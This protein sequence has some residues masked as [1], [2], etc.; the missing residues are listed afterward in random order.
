M[1]SENDVKLHFSA[2][3]F[4]YDKKDQQVLKK[5]WS[6]PISAS[7]SDWWLM[8]EMGGLE[9]A[10][11]DSVIPICL[12]HFVVSLRLL[13]ALSRERVFIFG[14]NVYTRRRHRRRHRPTS[15]DY[16]C[17]VPSPP[18]AV[19]QRPYRFLIITELRIVFKREQQ[20]TGCLPLTGAR[21]YS[22]VH[23]ALT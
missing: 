9:W 12:F 5:I 2:V 1:C 14:T 13:N 10:A 15:R 16:C 21:S 8:G 20:N 22:Y 6:S 18:G 3:Y 7:K 11:A 4:Q 23:R 19:L 17:T